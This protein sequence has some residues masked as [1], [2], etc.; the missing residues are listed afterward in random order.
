MTNETGEF[1]CGTVPYTHG[2][3]I[4]APHPG[5]SSV[6]TLPYQIMSAIPERVHPDHSA[7]AAAASAPAADALCVYYDGGCPLCRAEIASYQRTAGGESLRWVDAHAGN[8]AELGPDL[9]AV[10]AL[11]RMHVRRPDGTLL[12]GAAAFAEI[13]SHLPKW[14]WLARLARLPGMLPVLDVLYTVFLAIRPL[15]RGRS[16]SAAPSAFPKDLQRELRTDHAGEIGAVMIYRGVLAVTRDPELRAFARHHLETEQRHLDLIE[17]VVP[18]R[19]RSTLL[20]LWRASGWLTGALP[21]CIGPRAVYATIQAVEMFVDRHYAAQIE[22]IDVLVACKPTSARG[23]DVDCA[24][25]DPLQQLRQLL[26]TC[27]ADEV[28]HRDDA[29]SRWNNKPG[30]LM[31][32]WLWFVS[33]GSANAVLVCRYV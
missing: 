31:R 4:R 15:W 24:I 8:S 20:A 22:Q 33:Q 6:T 28:S 7:A 9:D 18:P 23:G 3:G 29:G 27:Q 21:A 16:G 32:T 10:T 13:W 11:A 17:T 30:A 26:I 2:T 5:V 12:Q 19:S 1:L 25:A 14:R